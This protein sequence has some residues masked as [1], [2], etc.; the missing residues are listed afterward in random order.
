MHRPIDESVSGRD[1]QSFWKV[2]EWETAPTLQEVPSL[3]LDRLAQ[4][5]S[6]NLPL[7]I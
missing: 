2:R 7:R 4:T 6:S 1:L 3:N 5:N